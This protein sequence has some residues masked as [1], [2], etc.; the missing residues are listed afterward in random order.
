LGRKPEPAESEE[1][2]EPLLLSIFTIEADRKPVLAFISRQ[3]QSSI[4]KGGVEFI[5][6]NGGAGVR[7]KKRAAKK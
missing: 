4:E 6:E 7:M 5:A 3:Y 1:M 2:K